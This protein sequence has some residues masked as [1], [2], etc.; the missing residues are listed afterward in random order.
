M[1]TFFA[2]LAEY[3]TSNIPL[4]K[5]SHIFG[6]APEE[7]AKRA[8]R[9]TLPVPAFRAGSQKSPWLLDATSLAS[10]LDQLKVEAARD[11]SRIQGSHI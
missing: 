5:C 7:A 10:Y 8:N 1:N 4:E 2:L 11:W 9:Q 3:G 6:L